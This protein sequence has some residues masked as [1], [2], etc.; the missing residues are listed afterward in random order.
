MI[1]LRNQVLINPFETDNGYIKRNVI[2]NSKTIINDQNKNNVYEELLSYMYCQ[3]SIN[4]FEK[5]I[6]LFNNVLSIIYESDRLNFDKYLD[7]FMI[8]N[9]I[10]EDKITINKNNIIRKIKKEKLD[11]NI[12][13]KILSII[14][15]KHLN[16]ITDQIVLCNYYYKNP[17]VFIEVMRVIRND[18]I[19]RNKLV[20]SN[21]RPFYILKKDESE[22]LFLFLDQENI[23][24]IIDT[25]ISVLNIIFL[26]LNLKFNKEDKLVI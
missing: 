18:I 16:Y 11:S 7:E 21:D 25:Y 10:K 9:K 24:K 4:I 3:I 19:H 15:N 5:V 22:N 12:A 13:I 20:A 26:T 8:D 1:R 17:F 23:L 2:I 14:L 6:V